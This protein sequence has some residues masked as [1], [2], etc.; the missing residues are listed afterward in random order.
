MIMKGHYH[1]TFIIEEDRRMSEYKEYTASELMLHKLEF[2][3]HI[4]ALTG[5]I[6][7]CETRDLEKVSLLDNVKLR[8]TGAL[9]EYARKHYQALEVN[10]EDTVRKVAW[11][12]NL[13]DR[14]AIV[15]TTSVGYFTFAAPGY[16]VIKLKDEPSYSWNKRY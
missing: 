9:M 10:F 11:S 1:L 7:R 16:E 2:Q 4:E 12:I 14:S 15:M 3:K 5:R 13:R 6:G 8:L